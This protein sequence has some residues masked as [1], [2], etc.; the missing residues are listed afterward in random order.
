MTDQST[1]GADVEELKRLAEAATPG[2]WKQTDWQSCDEPIDAGVATESGQAV[3]GTMQLEDA[4]FIAA[5]NPQA[6]LALIAEIARLKARLEIDPRHNYDGIDCRD[7]TIRELERERDHWKANHD[8][9]VAKN[10]LLSQRPDLPVDRIPAAKELERLRAELEEARRDDEVRQMI[11]A[12]WCAGYW[13][14]GYTHDSAYANEKAAEC[15]THLLSRRCLF[16]RAEV[17]GEHD[18]DCPQAVSQKHG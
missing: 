4:T 1:T 8:N 13:D 14:A 5:A 11:E 10:A 9:M 2:P 17:H 6:V 18:E 12:A 15:A 3:A 16:C 7:V